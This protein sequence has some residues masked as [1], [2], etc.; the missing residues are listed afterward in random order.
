MC[1]CVSVRLFACVLGVGG[2]VVFAKST[3]SY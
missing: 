1:L 3:G 2:M